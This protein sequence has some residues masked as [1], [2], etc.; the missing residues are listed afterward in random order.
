MFTQITQQ[1]MPEP[2]QYQY[3]NLLHGKNIYEASLKLNKSPD[4]YRLQVEHNK[5]APKHAHQD[6]SNLI[7]EL[8]DRNLSPRT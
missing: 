1:Q 4:N 7:N 8:A 6:I 5:Y 3:L 2:N